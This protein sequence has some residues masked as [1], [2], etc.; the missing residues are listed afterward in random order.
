M[1]RF[2]VAAIGV[3]GSLM[4][5]GCTV[6]AVPE[7][8]TGPTAYIADSES[9]RDANAVDFFYVEEVDGRDIDN[10]LGMTRQ[11]NYGQGFSMRPVVIGREVE[12]KPSK[13]KI[14]GRTNHSAPILAFLNREF[15]I[16]GTVEFSPE[17]NHR[18]TVRG[19]MNDEHSII[20][21]EDDATHTPVADKIEKKGVSTMD[22]WQK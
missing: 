6:P 22:L 20:W 1:R 3:A 8:D 11:A 9:R 17:V 5:A 7:G 4:L 2:F 14:V 18:Y 13:Y 15:Y 12:A 21:I 16:K 10:S 19:E